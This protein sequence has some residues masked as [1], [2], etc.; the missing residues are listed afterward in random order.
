MN[1]DSSFLVSPASPAHRL[2]VCCAGQFEEFQKIPGKGLRGLK[3]IVVGQDNLLA[4]GHTRE[5]ESYTTK[6]P[7]YK[8]CNGKFA[9]K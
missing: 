4:V 6:S 2:C 9:L 3:H 1:Y 8:W 5:G 7:I